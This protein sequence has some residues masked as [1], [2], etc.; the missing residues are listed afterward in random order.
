MSNFDNNGRG[1][2]FDHFH[3]KSAYQSKIFGDYPTSYSEF[4]EDG[5]YKAN[6]NATTWDDLNGS[7]LTLQ[8][9]GVGLSLNATESTLEFT[10]A[11][12]LSDYAF[13]NYQNRHR[14]KAG[15][16]VNP[17]I[18]W[19]QANNNIPNFLIRYR[20]QRNLNSKT[21]AWTDYKCT[22]P[23]ATYVSGT[24]NQI[25]HGAGITPPAGY[26]I[27]DVLELRVFRDNANNSG[28]FTGSDQYTGTVGVTFVDIHIEEDT[29][30]SRTEYAK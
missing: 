11:A 14:W 13:A 1:G 10:T 2:E 17:H 21:T 7:A 3:M 5:T 20:W 12:N 16:V 27:S 9:Q 24:F 4:E 22:T 15:S 19:E 6:G 28:V 18:H 29:L 30:G 25:C 23:V 26:N 8:V